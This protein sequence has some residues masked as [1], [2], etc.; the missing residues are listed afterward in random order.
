[1]PQENRRCG[2]CRFGENI[3][4]DTTQRQCR[5]AAPTNGAATGSWPR[6]K[7]DDWCFQY[8]PI[9][10]SGGAQ[11]ATSRGS[12]ANAD[13]TIKQAA[14]DSSWNTVVAEVNRNNLS[15]GGR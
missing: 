14:V 4:N 5:R 6:V 7:L 1:M 13:S 9:R 8:E 12:L 10:G 15:P 11:T 3:R 2:D